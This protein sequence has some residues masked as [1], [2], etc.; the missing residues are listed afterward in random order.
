MQNIASQIEDDVECFRSKRDSPFEYIKTIC[1][2]AERN[3]VPEVVPSLEALLGKNCLRGHV[4]RYDDDMRRAGDTVLE[5]LAY[6]ELC[7]G[8]ALARCADRRGYDILLAYLDDV[9]GFL[10]RSAEDELT[11]LLGVPPSRDRSGWQSLLEER[12]ATLRPKP[13]RKRID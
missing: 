9:R 3:P 7:I 5:R 6:L 10:A 1:A 2:V 13:F 11:D 12:R 4:V 8:R